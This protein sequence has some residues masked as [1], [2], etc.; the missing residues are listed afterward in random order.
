M[1][2]MVNLKTH[3]T[4]AR[5]VDVLMRVL[6]VRVCACSCLSGCALALMR[7]LPFGCCAFWQMCGSVPLHQS[8]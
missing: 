4:V 3:P 6:L 2:G 7:D 5:C 8:P 1:R